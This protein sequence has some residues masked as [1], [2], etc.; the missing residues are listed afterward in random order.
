M[1]CF[2]KNN[3]PCILCLLANCLIEPHFEHINLAFVYLII[4]IRYYIDAGYAQRLY[5]LC[6]GPDQLIKIRWVQHQHY[7]LVKCVGKD[8]IFDRG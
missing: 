4:L 8:K 5:F 3:Q 1:A 7:I 2:E 6:A